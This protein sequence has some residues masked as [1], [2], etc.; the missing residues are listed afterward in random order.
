MS[1]SDIDNEPNSMNSTQPEPETLE[2]V[3]QKLTQATV[4]QQDLERQI[5]E[6]TA[7]VDF[8][9][10]LGAVK[11]LLHE[12]GCTKEPEVVITVIK[13]DLRLK[14]DADHHAVLDGELVPLEHYIDDLTRKVPEWFGPDV[15]ARGLSPPQNK[16][17]AM[18]RD[19]GSIRR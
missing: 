12:Y 2:Q 19:L 6:S 1:N 17:E 5:D 16:Y 7:R 9:D 13:D 15:K 14:E 18:R 10:R 4:K 3:R 11:D 8:Q